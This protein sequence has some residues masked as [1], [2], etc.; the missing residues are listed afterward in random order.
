VFGADNNH[1]VFGPA[2]VDAWH[3]EGLRVC[4]TV[5]STRKQLSKCRL[6]DRR[7]R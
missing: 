5:E 2:D 7:R 3:P 1:V 6:F 4:N